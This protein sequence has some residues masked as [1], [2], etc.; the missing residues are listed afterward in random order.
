MP[1]EAKIH[2]RVKHVYGRERIYANCA[3]AELLLRLTGAKTF[4]IKHIAILRELGYDVVVDTPV[5]ETI[6]GPV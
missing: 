4:D 6:G 5:V 1:V 3:N 2:V